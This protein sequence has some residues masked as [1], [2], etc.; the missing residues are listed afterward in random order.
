M[1]NFDIGGLLGMMGGLQQR[2]QEMKDRAAQTEVT[3]TAAGGLVEV[4]MSCDYEVRGVRIDAAALAD[5]EL[6]EDLVRAAID[7]S[8]RRVKEETMRQVSELTGGLPI[9]PGL[10]PGMP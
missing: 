4:R 3:G 7:E 9:P 8:L 1:E 5:R 2:M 6:L 10:L